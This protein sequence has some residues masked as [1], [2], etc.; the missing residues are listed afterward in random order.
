[1]NN[2]VATG[3]FESVERGVNMPINAT[4][5]LNLHH[6]TADLEAGDTLVLEIFDADTSVWTTLPTYNGNFATGTQTYDI[7]G[8]RS[9]DT[10]IRFRISRAAIQW[11]GEF[12]YA[13]NVR[14]DYWS[15]S[16]HGSTSVLPTVQT[17]YIPVPEDQGL[18]MLDAV[19]AA[20]INPMVLYVSMT[21]NANGTIIYYDQW[22]D[23]FEA[24][25]RQPAAKHKRGLGR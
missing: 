15:P 24:E 12:F 14:I 4:A 19:N 17:Y 2:S 9:A 23:G 5:T 22:E 11:H 1:M 21:V 6:R 18:L 13:D 25:D 3:T 16:T 20:A 10:R 8:Y 7:S